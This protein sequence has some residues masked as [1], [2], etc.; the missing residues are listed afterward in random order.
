MIS[1]WSES[2]TCR[3]NEISIEKSVL[4]LS[5]FSIEYVTD[6]M[7]VVPTFS[8]EYVS[9]YSKDLSDQLGLTGDSA[10]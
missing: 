1:W 4:N 5:L 9:C 7:N 10:I 2:V 8:V 6:S 3:I